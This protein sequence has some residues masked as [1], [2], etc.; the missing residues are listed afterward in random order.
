MFQKETLVFWVAWLFHL[1][2]TNSFKKGPSA[3][4]EKEAEIK[5]RT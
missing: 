3:M 5:L 2:T 1:G 4:L